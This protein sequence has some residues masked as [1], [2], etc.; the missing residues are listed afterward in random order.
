METFQDFD[1]RKHLET[2]YKLVVILIID[3]NK[4]KF[5]IFVCLVVKYFE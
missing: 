3:K 1:W 2:R 4:F 5:R